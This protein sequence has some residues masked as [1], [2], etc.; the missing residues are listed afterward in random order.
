MAMTTQL[1]RQYQTTPLQGAN[2]AYV[3]ALYEAFLDNPGSVPREWRQFFAGLGNDGGEGVALQP[4]GE[5]PPGR[6]GPIGIQEQEARK[7]AQDDR[8]N[9]RRVSQGQQR[10]PIRFGPR[11]YQVWNA[12]TARRVVEN[13]RSS[14]Q[15]EAPE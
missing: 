12:F 10:A 9:L 15:R 11:P 2:A 13:R 3:E 8:M 4:H 7:P 1:K 6:A 14:A 5:F